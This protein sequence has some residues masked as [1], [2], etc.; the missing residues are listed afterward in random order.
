MDDNNKKDKNHY[1]NI[2][3]SLIGLILIVAFGLGYLY[4]LE[5]INDNAIDF[6]SIMVL[7]LLI[8]KILFP[9]L[10]IILLIAILCKIKKK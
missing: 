9:L 7:F 6:A 10:V 3:T 8:L 2:W 4:L 5:L 1:K